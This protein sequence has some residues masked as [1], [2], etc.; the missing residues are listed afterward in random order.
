MRVLVIGATG[1]L[2]SYLV[3]SL[4]RAGHEVISM[5][6]GKHLPYYTGMKEW[7]EVKSV[8]GFDMFPVDYT[9]ENWEKAEL[10]EW[11]NVKMVSADRL[12]LEK[13]GSF[14]KMITR[15]K[16][17]IICDL[18]C[19][20]VQQVE[21]LAK[22]ISGKVRQYL[23][24]GTVWVYDYNITVPADES[25]PR[26]ALSEY[27][28]GKIEMENRLLEL[29]R[30]GILPSTILHAGHIVGC[31]WVPLNPQGNFNRD[32]FEDIAAGRPLLL[33]D[34]GLATLHHVHAKDISDLMIDCINNP[35]ISISQAF[36]ATSSAA[37]TL[38]GYA[39]SMY[40]KFNREPNIQYMPLNDMLKT[41]TSD[42]AAQTFEHVSRS[43]CA[44]M[45]KARKE[46][47]FIPSY[48]SIHA[49][50]ESV[51]FLSKIGAIKVE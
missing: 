22:H 5:T 33:P 43:P 1:H 21:H 41:L 14:G 31:G 2:G 7:K 11:K 4:V 6:R 10:D 35:D 38:R 29:S 17:E 49:V 18:I 15:L 24:M 42:D 30:T 12:L 34:T 36:H 13:N 47:G 25:H 48:S 46:L 45:E 23:S 8:K 51:D 3:P 28:R 20:N 44:S 37:L 19:Y 32:I 9:V 39:E 50:I 26:N 16:P 27:G 40:K